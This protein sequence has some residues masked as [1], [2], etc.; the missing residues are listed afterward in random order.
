MN[1]A[2]ALTALQNAT[3]HR[4][5]TQCPVNASAE[6]REFAL[7]GGNHRYII[8]AAEIIDP[9]CDTEWLMLNLPN[10]TSHAFV[11]VTDADASRMGRL[12]ANMEKYDRY[13]TP[14]CEYA[15]IALADDEFLTQNGRVGA[16]M[17]PVEYSSSL[18]RLGDVFN[19]H[20]QRIHFLMPIFL[21]PSENDLRLSR[22]VDALLASWN[23]V[24]RDLVTL[25]ASC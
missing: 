19:F 1:T 24:G 18:H 8:A 23:K 11:T 12:L 14:I 10:A 9:G 6:L 21:S 13:V 22:G 16:M 20:G 5:L 7:V 4:V 15:Y 25:A 17:V 3:L 2:I